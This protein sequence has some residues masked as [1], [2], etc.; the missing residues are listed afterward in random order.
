MG[1]RNTL[2][3]V[4]G[5]TITSAWGL[6]VR[7]HVVPF[8]T[9]DDVSSNGQIAVNTS[10]ARLVG[11]LGGVTYP[12]AGALPRVRVQRSFV[13][14]VGVGVNTPIQFDVEAYDTDNLWTNLAPTRL[15]ASVRGSWFVSYGC[16]IESAASNGNHAA[17]ITVNGTTRFGQQILRIAAN[18]PCQLSTAVDIVLNAGDY[19]ELVVN[20]TAS[21]GAS[22]MQSVDY[23]Q[24]RYLGP[25]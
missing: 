21:S 4:S 14:A 17:F 25:A 20:T 24:M 9:S 8:T 7:D 19:V 22:A 16:G 2:T 18:D 6:G 15:T 1:A 12:L 11:R 23:F 3:V 10:T 13:Q 5:T